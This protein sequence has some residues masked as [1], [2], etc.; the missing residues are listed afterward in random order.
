M[1]CLSWTLWASVLCETSVPRDKAG[2]IVIYRQ[3]EMLLLAC[4]TGTQNGR[5]SCCAVKL[6]ESVALVSVCVLAGCQPTA[7]V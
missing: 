2:L 3:Q 1:A 5:D 6:V 4:L 7:P